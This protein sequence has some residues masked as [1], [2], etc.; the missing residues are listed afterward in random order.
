MKVFRL[1]ICLAF[2]FLILLGIAH[3]NERNTHR[4]LVDDEK[5]LFQI[6]SKALIDR[7]V[8]KNV[9]GEM[10]LNKHNDVW[11]L[12]DPVKDLADQKI[13]EGLVDG[14][15]KYRFDRV[16]SHK[17][18]DM[19]KYGLVEPSTS[20]SLWVKNEKHSIELGGKAP[21]G[22][23]VYGRVNNKQNSSLLVN[24]S[25]FLRLSKGVF[26]LRSKEIV[27]QEF[28]NIEE[29]VYQGKVQEPIRL[30]KRK[31]GRWDLEDF[32]FEVDR[33]DLADFWTDIK[34]IRAIAILDKPDERFVHL[35]NTHKIDRFRIKLRW[36]DK[37]G[38]DKMIEFVED[39]E[40]AY[41]RFRDDRKIFR[42]RKSGLEIMNRSLADFIRRRVFDFDSMSITR[43]EIDDKI[44]LKNG[45]EWSGQGLTDH[46][47]R[48]LIEA[49]AD[50]EFVK[51]TR[52][53]KLIQQP[54]I[55]ELKVWSIKDD[56]S[57]NF[58]FYEGDR[59]GF[60]WVYPVK[61]RFYFE[62]PSRFGNVLLAINQKLAAVDTNLNQSDF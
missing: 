58:V 50:M 12:A 49:L 56:S 27:R 2:I 43:L 31:N 15:L 3:W 7:L 36:K 28:E 10:T 61:G 46:L 62:V 39:G 4:K 11:Y 26:S 19:R 14:V 44:Y 25:L 59:A 45:L 41:A 52:L 1:P 53:E 42:I 34:S 38:H 33:E 13:V 16:L 20:L 35:F 29:L 5:S 54:R 22:Y 57:Q 21:V 18:G 32:D 51:A 9:K 6:E 60:H 37:S 23:Y 24:Q 47:R 8:L 40:D 17:S 30:I 48:E 55:F